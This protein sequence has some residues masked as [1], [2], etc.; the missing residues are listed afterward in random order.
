MA[1]PLASSSTPSRL[2]SLLVPLA[3][4]VFGFLLCAAAFGGS[5]GS[6][7]AG[8]G[9]T[10]QRRGKVGA[11][12]GRNGGGGGAGAGGGG[13]S[14]A[15]SVIPRFWSET[16]TTPATPPLLRHDRFLISAAIYFG[17]ISNAKSS[18][19][20]VVA[21]AL[22]TNR[23]AVLPKL[24]ECGADGVE[25]SVDALF[26]PAGFARA[27][28]L[29][30]GA[31]DFQAACAGSV[32]FL[33]SGSF[34]GVGA[35]VGYQGVEVPVL[36]EQ[37]QKD[38]V[39]ASPFSGPGSPEEAV[40]L[41]PY[42]TY[43]APGMLRDVPKYMRDPLLPDKIAG[44]TERCV[45]LGKNYMALNWPRLPAG[46][47]EEV[48][49]QL[50]PHASVRTEAEAFWLLHG[51]LDGTPFL[52]IHL[53][54]GDFLSDAGHRSFGV[55]CNV[56]PELIVVKVREMLARMPP[57]AAAAAAAAGGGG[58]G[59]SSPRQVIVLATDD[60]NVACAVALKK[61]FPTSLVPLRSGSVFTGPSCKAALFDQEVLG[62]A[63]AF[64][65]DGKSTFS[66]S[67]HQIRTV[68]HKMDPT[69][70]MWL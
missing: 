47:Y 51:L 53:R 38:A 37:Q 19:V 54:M 58:G 25:A 52:G 63:A 7:Q 41:E 40:K 5:L 12:R 67:I 6:R 69:T 22:A 33:P 4:F 36:T 27:S 15:A 57:A 8:L 62:R 35:T 14:G 23:T 55:D 32:V 34:G 28:V 20:E 16:G 18:L 49:G 31:F 65:G 24:E 2:R 13:G 44:R 68:R 70:T 17:R 61:A 46:T 9:G 11:A 64:I 10:G 21:L 66:Q 1:P 45:V 50:L 48:A 3:A 59:S 43:F 56:D 26:D 42:R 60:Y 39:A 29:S 30:V